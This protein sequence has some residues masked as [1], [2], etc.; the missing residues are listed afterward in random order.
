MVVGALEDH[1]VSIRRET[2]SCRLEERG[3][4]EKK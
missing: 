2:R 4:C 1:E 3:A